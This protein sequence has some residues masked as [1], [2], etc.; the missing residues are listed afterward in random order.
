MD[1][2]QELVGKRNELEATNKKI[3]KIRDECKLGDGSFDLSRTKE[4][5]GDSPSRN[6]SMST[7]LTKSHE[8][9]VEVDKLADLVKGM[10]E[11][12]EGNGEPEAKG[13]QHPEP[14]GANRK[15]IGEQFIASKEF[16]ACAGDGG[17][18]TAKFFI[19]DVNLKTLMTTSAGYA[20]QAIR[21]GETEMYRAEA[22]NLWNAIPKRQTSQSSYIYMEET[23]RT[24][25]AAEKAEAAAYAESAFAFTER[26]VPV[27][28]VGHWLPITRKQLLD[29]PQIQGIVDS[30]LTLGL[31]ELLEYEAINGSGT[32][33]VLQGML[34]KTGINT[35][36]AGGIAPLDAIYQAI[37]KVQKNGLAEPNLVFVN[38]EDWE[39]I[40]LMKTTGGQYIWGHPAD[41]GPMRVWGR[42]L[43]STFRVA[44]GTGGVG[45]FSRMLYAERMGI[46]IEITDSHASYFISNYY[47]IRAWTMG[48]FVWKRPTAFCSITGLNS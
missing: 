32:T 8:L 1:T 34:E 43:Y 23:T 2:N 4:L 40:Q 27:E 42:K 26:T 46:T 5:D 44:Q 37:T 35:L 30:E 9:G 16:Q 6:N 29:V 21:T 41:I 15:S 48:C 14:K 20:S 22:L 45:D 7:L 47:A 18:K 17:Q 28:D 33:P 10:M 25:A 13:M 19:P 31:Q 11:F 36:S 3:K 24:Q 38:G 12:D 39:P